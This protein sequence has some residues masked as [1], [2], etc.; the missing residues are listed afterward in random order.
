[1][2]GNILELTHLLLKLSVLKF[3]EKLSILMKV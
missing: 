2:F 3:K 1:M